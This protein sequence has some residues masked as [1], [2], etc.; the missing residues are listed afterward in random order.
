[1][2]SLR[3]FSPGTPIERVKQELHLKEIIK[4]ASDKISIGP[5][6]EAVKL[7][8]KEINKINFYPKGSIKILRKK[9]AHKLS[10]K[11]EM[12]I[13]SSGVDNVISLIKVVFINKNDE[14]IIVKIKFP[15]YERISRIV[16]G[17]YFCKVRR[18][19]I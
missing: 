7:I 12:V 3:G 8:K 2:L 11:E 5:S 16:V 19:Q 9:L 15:L 6:P 17:K 13:I 4:L 14:I 18:F 1:M 10:T